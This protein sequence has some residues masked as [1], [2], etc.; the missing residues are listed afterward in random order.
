[1]TIEESLERD[2]AGDML[3]EAV[4]DGL[5]VPGATGW[6]QGQAELVERHLSTEAEGRGDAA[7]A[8]SRREARG[9]AGAGG[10]QRARTA[11]G[12][13]ACRWG[14]ADTS[15]GRGG[16]RAAALAARAARRRGQ[17]DADRCAAASL[18]RDAVERY[19]DW[20]DNEDGSDAVSRSRDL[21]ARGAAHDG[22]RAQAGPSPQRH[23][24]ARPAR[25]EL[26]ADPLRCSPRSPRRSP[27]LAG[28]RNSISRSRPSSAGDEQDLGFQELHLLVA[29]RGI[30]GEQT[31]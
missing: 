29:F 5:L 25:T 4:D 22:R 13:D 31:P 11:R 24:Q 1:M 10:R 3:E 6:R 28:R 17:A 9:M 14:S 16:G 30:V 23:P 15:R 2:T 18:V 7:L 19:P 27:R 26:R 12:G 20:W 8:A 21:P